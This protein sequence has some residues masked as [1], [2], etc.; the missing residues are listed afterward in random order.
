MPA[1]LTST[2]NR[3]ELAA[4][5]FDQGFDLRTLRHV[6]R[7]PAP[8]PAFILAS[9]RGRAGIAGGSADHARTER[10]E[11]IGIAAPMRDWRR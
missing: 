8:L 6:E 11:L 1:L 10:R 3:A 7:R 9:I 4:D 2:L 5:R